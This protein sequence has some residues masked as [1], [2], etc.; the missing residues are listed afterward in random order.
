MFE[1]KGYD[2]TISVHEVNNQILSCNLHY[3]TDV[4]MSPKFGNCSISMIF[5]KNFERTEKLIFCGFLSVGTTYDLG[6][7]PK[8]RE[9]AWEKLVREGAGGVI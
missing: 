6:E 1:N 7:V 8:F 9:V 4:V 3:I 2:V 5:Y